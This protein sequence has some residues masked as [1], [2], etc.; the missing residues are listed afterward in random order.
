[1]RRG[2]FPAQGQVVE[3]A[4]ETFGGLPLGGE[5]GGALRDRG[6]ATGLRFALRGGGGVRGRELPLERLDLGLFI[7][8]PGRELFFLPEEELELLLH[9]GGFVPG[10]RQN[11]EAAQVTVPQ[12]ADV[13]ILRG[14]LV[15]G[16][17]QVLRGGRDALLEVGPVGGQGF[18]SGPAVL[19]FLDDEDDFLEQV[20]AVGLVAAP[21]LVE[22]LDALGLPLDLAFQARRLGPQAEHALAGFLDGF[23]EIPQPVPEAR[24]LPLFR[25]DPAAHFLLADEAAVVGRDGFMLDSLEV[26]EPALVVE[27]RELADPLAEPPVAVGRLGLPLERVPGALHLGDDV[28]Q[29]DEVL[30]GRF[31]LVLGLALLVLVI[32]RARGFLQEEPLF[33][34][35]RSD[36]VADGPLL[37][38]EVARLADG[39]LPELVL[40]VLEPGGL[41]VEPVLA[42]AGPEDAVGDDEV[43]VLL[44]ERQG[45]VGHAQGRVLGVAVE[46]DVLGPVAA[47][48]FDAGPAE[49][50][51]HGVDEVAFSGAVRADDGRDPGMEGDFR[52]LGEGLEA[53]QFELFNAHEIWTL[54]LRKRRLPAGRI[55]SVLA[56]G[57]V[58]ETEP[59]G[60]RSGAREDGCRSR[61]LGGINAAARMYEEWEPRRDAGAPGI[62]RKEAEMFNDALFVP[63]R[64]IRRK[65]V[66]WPVSILIHTA[67]VLFAVAYPLLSVGELPKV[68]SIG[69]FL[70]PPPPVPPPPPPKARGGNP[71]ARTGQKPGSRSPTGRPRRRARSSSRASSPTRSSRK[72]WAATESRA[73][74]KAASTTAPPRPG[75]SSSATRKSTRLS[76]RN[77]PLSGRV[78]EV[79]PPR[80]VRRVEP[81]YPEIARQARVEGVVI[82]EATTDEYGRV[83]NIR[84]LRSIPLLDQA[85]LEAVRGWVYE[86]MVINGRPRAVVFTV[87]VRFKLD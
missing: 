38:D 63:E 55:C 18:Q 68:E 39:V 6:F 10:F 78:G 35:L 69:V 58:V 60:K 16:G 76:A 86:P 71:G 77:R 83:R 17:P 47:E 29:A 37:D 61:S 80:L 54:F 49:N 72:R 70:A 41:A 21:L 23:F 2:P 75:P 48:R 44:A 57:I 52:A 11:L 34:G 42:L 30:P 7:G 84:V 87:T 24:Q 82:L 51:Q 56:G 15:P 22:I 74:S 40:D 73:A 45:D 3:P 25:L 67:F 65:A 53:L 64:G 66:A 32:R 8:D 46:D 33:G 28:L 27:G 12:L 26:E 59:F 62:L 85:A 4:P 14:G 1:M 5:G 50:P 9:P 79:K 19:H 31:E 13:V 43:L 20:V 81:L 36:E